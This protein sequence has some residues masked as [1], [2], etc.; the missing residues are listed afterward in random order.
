MGSPVRPSLDMSSSTNTLLHPILIHLKINSLQKLYW[1]NTLAAIGGV[2]W[3]SWMATIVISSTSGWPFS[4]IWRYASLQLLFHLCLLQ[5]PDFW[6][7]TLQKYTREYLFDRFKQDYL[8]Q[9]PPPPQTMSSRS[10]ASSMSSSHL[11]NLSQASRP[12][13]AIDTAQSNPANRHPSLAM[14]RSSVNGDINSSSIHSAPPTSQRPDLS[15]ITSTSS[16]Q[17]LSF[18]SPL[19]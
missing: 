5:T 13:L 14:P 18:F 11:L 9:H 12:I 3:M 1:E 7:Q 15:P 4:T 10:R 2:R 16:S 6:N 19:L 8:V 17:Y